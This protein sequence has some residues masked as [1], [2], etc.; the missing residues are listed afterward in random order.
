M[1]RAD[2]EAE[3][4]IVHALHGEVSVEID[5]ESIP[6]SARESLVAR[7]APRLAVTAALTGATVILIAVGPPGLRMA[8]P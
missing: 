8:P 2:S 3:V 7:G 5:G 1:L 6:L 4:S